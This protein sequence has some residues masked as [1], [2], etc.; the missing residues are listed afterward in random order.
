MDQE[1]GGKKGK[2]KG[3]ESPVTPLAA[4]GLFK[5]EAKA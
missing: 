5:K 1:K 4:V 2:G 3:K